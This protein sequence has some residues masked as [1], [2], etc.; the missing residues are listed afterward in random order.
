MFNFLRS[1]QTIFKR[2]TPLVYISTRSVWGFQFLHFLTNTCYLVFFITVQWLKWHLIGFG[3]CGPN[4]FPPEKIHFYRYITYLFTYFGP[5]EG[6]K[7]S[8]YLSFFTN[9]QPIFTPL[10]G[11]ILPIENVYH[12]QCHR[13]MQTDRR[14]VFKV[15][16]AG[17]IL[18]PLSGRICRATWKRVAAER[19]DLGLNAQGERDWRFGLM[20]T[21]WLPHGSTALVAGP[22]HLEESSTSQPDFS[23]PCR[24]WMRWKNDEASL[25]PWSSLSWGALW[26]PPSQPWAKPSWSRTSCLGQELRYAIRLLSCPRGH[27]PDSDRVLVIPRAGFQWPVTFSGGLLLLKLSQIIHLWE[28]HKF[29]PKSNPSVGCWMRKLCQGTEHL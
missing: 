29:H 5:L 26:K 9:P 8:R 4:G 18:H 23:V 1:R 3:L 6:H 28:S 21:P 15:K 13:G 22:L 19:V 7:P 14:T 24:S 11:A 20:R 12:N 27:S 10:G 16:G 2:K 25:L 17:T